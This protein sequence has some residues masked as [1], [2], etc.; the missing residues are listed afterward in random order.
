MITDFTTQEDTIKEDGDLK[1]IVL[2]KTP[3]QS[4]NIM[5]ENIVI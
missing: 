3:A 5:E 4:L 1:K 2:P